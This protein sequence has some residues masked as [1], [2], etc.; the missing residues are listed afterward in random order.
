[1]RFERGGFEVGKPPQRRASAQTR[2]G[3]LEEV[4]IEVTSA[5]KTGSGFCGA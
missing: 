2:R 5:T 4:V 3:D 1:L